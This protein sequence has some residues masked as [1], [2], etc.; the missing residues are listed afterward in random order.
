MKAAVMSHTDKQI[1]HIVWT[2][3]SELRGSCR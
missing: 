1:P 3:R 2:E